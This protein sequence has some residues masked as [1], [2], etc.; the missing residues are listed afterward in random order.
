MVQTIMQ[1]TEARLYNVAYYNV[2]AEPGDASLGMMGLGHFHNTEV[3]FING[4]PEMQPQ[5]G[6]PWEAMGA[7]D[8]NSI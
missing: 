3:P 5:Q 7:S 2:V 8:L 6:P 1:I 4:Y